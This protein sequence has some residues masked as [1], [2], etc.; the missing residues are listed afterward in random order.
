MNDNLD[1][2]LNAIEQE[3]ASSSTYELS[4]YEEQEAYEVENYLR[5]VKRVSG[6]RA[7]KLAPRIVKNGAAL[8]QVRR[9]MQSDSGMSMGSGWN[10]PPMKAQTTIVITR[11]TANIPLALPVP[12]FGAIDSESGFIQSLGSALPAGVSVD[13]DFGVNNGK[14]DSLLLT[15]TQGA[16]VDGISITCNTIPYPSLL[17]AMQTDI[18]SIEKIRYLLSD[19]TKTNQ[20]SQTHEVVRASM[21]GKADRN[22]F[23]VSTFVSPLQQQLGIVDV[24]V[25]IAVDKESAIVL[26]VI[27]VAAF[28]VSLNL[29]V[30]S[31]D[32]RSIRR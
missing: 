1:I 29:F 7:S 17:K 25:N 24:D 6:R 12:I 32:R 21:F 2:L 10:V 22:L 23:D 3:S 26:D 14:A 20:Y 9:A 28:S 5:S 16:N 13:V 31:V 15:Y 18:L 19:N 30:S 11:A 4:S 27:N 8:Q